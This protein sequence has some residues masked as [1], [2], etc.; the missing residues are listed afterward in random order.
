MPTVRTARH[1]GVTL[2]SRI[3]AL[4]VALGLVLTASPAHAAEPRPDVGQ[5]TVRITS[6]LNVTLGDTISFVGEGWAPG[7]Y[8]AAIKI[9]DG[10][11]DG[12]NGGHL[13]MADV[14][15]VVTVSAQGTFSGSV[16][17]PGDLASNTGVPLPTQHWLRFLSGSINPGD[18]VTSK[19]T[20]KF[21]V[22][23]PMTS[24][25]PTVSPATGVKQGAT[26]T[27]RAGTWT[28][29]AAL[30]YQWRRNGAAIKGATKTTYKVA[31]AD[32]GAKV[33][34]AVTGTRTNYKTTS[35]V[36]N[37][38]NAVPYL[39][40][41][42]GKIKFSGKAKVGKKLTAKP[43]KW[44]SGV[45]Y[46]YQW[47]AKGSAIKGATGKTF[48]LTKAQKGKKV[49]VTVTVRKPGYAAVAKS[50]SAKKVK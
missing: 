38:T 24:S 32:A 43:S 42:T 46:S 39:K 50:S 3:V 20:A 28:S 6:S 37:P 21:T 36:S 44:P 8:Q 17:V 18:P 47:Y 26:L 7:P 4:L 25:K 22:L 34:V 12:S 2:A 10:A 16:L 35:Q 23:L 29:G 27:A 14:I 49:K 19:Q 11:Y 1:P 33:T 41:K 15:G 13:D 31:P 40:L 5:G 48:K 9:S 30:T 45:S